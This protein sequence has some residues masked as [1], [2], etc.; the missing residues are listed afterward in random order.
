MAT[1]SLTDERLAWLAVRDELRKR[2]RR[3][4]GQLL[5]RLGGAMPSSSN[6][7]SITSNVSEPVVVREQRSSRM[8]RYSIVVDDMVRHLSDEE[9]VILRADGAVPAWLCR[10]CWKKPS[11]PGS[12]MA[13][14]RLRDACLAG[15]PRR[16]ESDR[17]S[18]LVHTDAV[19]RPPRMDR[20]RVPS[21]PGPHRRLPDHSQIPSG[22]HVLGWCN[23]PSCG[24]RASSPAHV[25]GK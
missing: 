8:I 15:P 11:R 13:G 18:R 22:C 21:R 10:E 7:M 5:W 3:S 23:R 1:P 6:V 20:V 16:D 17:C 24:A 14:R 25:P 2:S 4:L 19:V 12:D 9:R